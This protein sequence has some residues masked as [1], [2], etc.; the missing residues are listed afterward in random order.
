M[1]GGEAMRQSK[2]GFTLVELVVVIA[3]LGI[4][5]A[6]ALPRF[7]SLGDDAHNAAVEHTAGALKTGI[8]QAHARW[9]LAGGDPAGNGIL[10]LAGFADGNIDFNPQGYPTGHNKRAS[11]DPYAIG[12]SKRGCVTI[13]QSVLGDGAPSVET[14]YSDQDYQA[15][16]IR[17]Q[18][19]AVKDTCVYVYRVAGDTSKHNTAKRK[20][21]YNASRGHVWAEIQP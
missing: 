13:W 12:R 3:L 9:Q 1:S 10:N 15:Y 8:I 16:R 4:L 6:V 14:N 7:L 20:I 19:G 2:K 21:Y 11:N 18:G 17:E 5:A